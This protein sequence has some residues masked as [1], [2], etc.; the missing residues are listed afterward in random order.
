MKRSILITGASSGIGWETALALANDVN[1]L[2]LSGRRADRLEELAGLCRAQGVPVNTRAVDLADES[3][4]DELCEVWLSVPGFPV[5]VNCAGVGIFQTFDELSWS[6][7]KSQIQ[8]NLMA[9]AQLIHCALPAMIE[10]GGGQIINVLSMAA[11][12][13]LSGCG[14]YSAS[15]AGLMMLGR[16]VSAEARAQGVRLTNLLPGAVATG[17][18]SGSPMEAR[19]SEMIPPQSVA[20]MIALIVESPGDYTVDELLMMPPKGV[21]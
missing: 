20:R 11:T 8:T 4:I 2:T 14:G 3:A 15:K 6:D 18:W 1:H 5:L 10:R 9:P 13:V 7:F 21:L 16:V 12:H 19:T 17:I